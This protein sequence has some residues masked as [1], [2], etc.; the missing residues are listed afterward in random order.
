M[1]DNSGR[2]ELVRPP[3]GRGLANRVVATDWDETRP[4][5]ATVATGSCHCELGRHSVS[6]HTADRAVVPRSG[7]PGEAGT[8]DER[9][10]V[11]PDAPGLRNGPRSG[12]PQGPRGLVPG[13]DLPELVQRD[14]AGHA[15]AGGVL[16]A[17][18]SAEQPYNGL[19]WTLEGRCRVVDGV[20]HRDRVGDLDAAPGDRQADLPVDLIGLA[21]KAQK[22]GQ[23]PAEELDE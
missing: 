12:A 2:G 10:W 16:G 17:E 14:V 7:E 15:H 4:P 1:A 22:E 9:T 13:E 3:S 23:R 5:R 21:G 20:G 6:A 8:A 18:A 11:W 19:C